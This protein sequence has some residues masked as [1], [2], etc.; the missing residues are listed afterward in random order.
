MILTPSASRLAWV[1]W[2]AL[3]ASLV[4]AAVLVGMP[5]AAKLAAFAAIAGH[6]VV[7]RPE[8][9]LVSIVVAADATCVVPQWSRGAVALGPRT[10]V[11]SHW[12]RLDLGAG[13]RLRDI[14]LFSD[15]LSHDQWARL[16]ALL[17]RARCDAAHVSTRSREPI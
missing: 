6:A 11:S 4:A 15:Q 1:W 17:A 14:V 10:L 9:P 8:P 12:L 13:P 2:C 16:C 3:H 7:R 5:W